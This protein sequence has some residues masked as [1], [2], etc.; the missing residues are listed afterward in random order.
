MQTFSK[1][2]SFCLILFVYLLSSQ[3]ERPKLKRMDKP[4]ISFHSK[5]CS[6]C[7]CYCKN[8]VLSLFIV[9]NFSYGFVWIL[10]KMFDVAIRYQ[11]Q[12]YSY[13][14]QICL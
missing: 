12:A 14:I 8:T 4:T 10:P 9:A 6:Y 5:S 1:P 11:K 2:K 3:N 7:S 13:P